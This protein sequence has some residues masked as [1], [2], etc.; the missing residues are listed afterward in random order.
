[1]LTKRWNK[2]LTKRLHVW[3]LVTPETGTPAIR[4]RSND[5]QRESVHVVRSRA[6]HLRPAAIPP[7]PP[8]SGTCLIANNWLFFRGQRIR[9]ACGRSSSTRQL[10]NESE[11]VR[12][13]ESQLSK[14][15]RVEEELDQPFAI[16]VRSTATVQVPLLRVQVQGEDRHTK[17]HQDEA[18]EQGC[19][20]DRCVPIVATFSVRTNLQRIDE[21]SRRGDTLFPRSLSL[22][23][24]LSIRGKCKVIGRGR[25]RFDPCR[26]FACKPFF[27]FF[28]L[29]LLALGSLC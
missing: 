26:R 27:F 15:V 5:D 10:V 7:I 16:S 28:L 3:F 8:P 12:L 6:Y 17:A 29:C 21:Y 18:Q 24:F 14:R 13:S 11:Q 22:V 20:R 4:N 23:S 9:V 1:M 19:L 2:I 25:G